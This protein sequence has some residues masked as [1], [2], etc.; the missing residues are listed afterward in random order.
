MKKTVLS[1]FAVFEAAFC[2]SAEPKLARSL[3][4]TAELDPAA[5]GA[6]THLVGV[7][8]FDFIAE[9]THLFALSLT[10]K[11]DFTRQLKVTSLDAAET[12]VVEG[13]DGLTATFRGFREGVE[14]VTVTVRGDDRL[15][16]RFDAKTKDGWVLESGECPRVILKPVWDGPAR[17]ERISTGHS[18]GGTYRPLDPRRKRGFPTADRPGRM[19]MQ[20]AGMFNPLRGLYTAAEDPANESK[21]LD[22]RPV[23]C[24]DSSD[25][26]STVK[27]ITWFWCWRLWGENGGA[28]PYDIVMKGLT[29]TRL[30][31]VDWR[32]LADVYRDWVM[33]QGWCAEPV[34]ERPDLPDWMKSGPAKTFFKRCWIADPDEIRR[35]M[36]EYYSPTFGD[37]PLVISFW[38]WEHQDLWVGPD[39]FPAFP[40]EDAFAALTRDLKAKGGHTFLWPSGFRWLTTFDLKGDGTYDHDDRADWDRV[41]KPHAVL[42]RDGSEQASVSAV[43]WRGGSNKQVCGYED[44]SV[45]WFLENAKHMVRLGAES[46]QV[47]QQGG[48]FLAPCW[49]RNHGHTPGEGVWKF[50]GFTRFLERLRDELKKV[51]P[52]LVLGMEAPGDGYNRFWGIQDH[53]DCE[54]SHSAE[55]ASTFNWLYHAYVPTFQS[56]MFM[57]RHDRP[58][59]AHCAVDG[60][61]PYAVPSRA[62]YAKGEPVIWNGGFET[63]APNGEFSGWERLRGEYRNEAQKGDDY[64]SMA[65]V[66]SGRAYPDR[67]D[68]KEGATSMRL[69]T[70]NAKDT[71]GVSQDLFLDDETFVAGATYRLG[72]WLKTDSADEPERCFMEPQ[73]LTEGELIV[74]D[75][76][77]VAFPK[78]GEGWKRVTVDFKLPEKAIL[79]RPHFRTGGTA[80]THVDGVTLERVRPDGTA[81]PVTFTGRSPYNRF[82]KKWI[83]LYHGEARKYLAHGRQIRGADVRCETFHYV[84]ECHVNLI[85]N[86]HPDSGAADDEAMPV[87]ASQSYEA[88]DGTKALVLGNTS[89][90]PQEVTYTWLGRTQRLTVAGDDLVVVPLPEEKILQK[91]DYFTAEALATADMDGVPEETAVALAKCDGEFAKAEALIAKLAGH[92]REQ[93]SCR[94]VMA[95]RLKAYVAKRAAAPERDEQILAWQGAQE[96]NAFFDYFAKETKRLRLDVSY[97]TRLASGANGPGRDAPG[98]RASL[99]VRDFGAKGDGTGDD[100]PAFRAALEAARKL[101][102]APCVIRVPAGRY[103]LAPDPR[104]PIADFRCRDLQTG[105]NSGTVTVWKGEKINAHL[106]ANDLDNV[107]LRGEGEKSV[108][109]FTDSSKG[110]IRVCGCNEVSVEDLAMD[111]P[112]NP[113]TQGTVVNVEENPFALVLKRDA[114]YP[115]PDLPRF[116]NAPSR[117][118][119]P[120]GE[121]LMYLPGGVARMGTVEKLGD[122]LFRL[123]PYAHHLKNEVWRSRKVGDRIC[124]MARF[125]ESEGGGPLRFLL[126]AFCGCRNVRAYD[127]PGQVFTQSQ[128]YAT[129]V[130]GCKAIG[131]DGS[132]DIVTSN[133]DAFLGGGLIGPYVADCEFRGLEDD[134]INVGTNTGDVPSIPKDGL[135]RQRRD[136]GG[137]PAAGGFLSNGVTGRI[138]MFLRYGP[139][140][141]G[142]APGTNCAS[143]EQVATR[144]L[145]GDAVPKSATKV[146]TGADRRKFDYNTAQKKG[147][148]RADRLIR[149]PGTVG[150]VLKDTSFSRI[151]GRGIQV[152]CGNMYIENVHVSDVTGVGISVN[153]L[154]PWGM[155]YDIHNVLVRDCVFERL[156]GVGANLAPNA[157]V[158]GE[159]LRQRMHFGISFE[160]CTFEPPAGKPAVVCMNDDDVSFDGC[161][162]R[163]VGVKDPIRVD[164]ATNVRVNGKPVAE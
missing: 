137:Q 46:V 155:C 140:R 40:S 164:N 144:P 58:F 37:I 71:V 116:L 73:T 4:L 41:A 27:G 2:V 54:A 124:I 123:K 141:G 47:D 55:W 38:G 118:F 8:G 50:Q 33:P 1:V 161:T 66:W 24:G 110:G 119:S 115:D 14:S 78:A 21:K 94:L 114:G 111:Y 138:K 34:A 11:E 163:T 49:A 120:V 112:D 67:A 121:G 77:R 32:D 68:A 7:D 132:D 149:I 147:V 101:N 153:A 52:D 25:Y 87:V 26:A 82:M 63:T 99:N 109:V 48:G 125:A 75:M 122:G 13:P 44:W 98:T 79:L 151:R 154:L 84:A 5:K 91:H 29:G 15:R 88:A 36:N 113:S 43:W 3:S 51:S 126:C 57:R 12:E 56:N 93:V 6:V 146:L 62:D 85:Y 42:R 162:F 81:V 86:G 65:R 31:P 127:S 96:L 22:V 157:L 16:W 23:C 30:R 131:R 83:T 95:K 139:C 97:P 90:K 142:D 108:L 133:A 19:S 135:L 136:G 158:K 159:P 64:Y 107:T 117:Y 128:S 72:A 61:L 105:E 20:Y 160:R 104:C 100:A 92:D 60:Q 130:I 103:R 74:P 156:G 39:Y 59:V 70:L 143:C 17:G 76:P 28:Q 18:N 80:V 89:S 148:K 53:R 35:W 102:G 134:G 152:H 129:Y 45:N 69:V 10:R 150:A 145:P 106:I 9:P